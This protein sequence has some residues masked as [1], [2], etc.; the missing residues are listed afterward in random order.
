[1]TKSSLFFKPLQWV[2][3]GATVALATLSQPACAQDLQ[4]LKTLVD[5]VSPG[6]W[7]QANT[8][9]FISAFPVGSSAVPSSGLSDSGAVVRAWSSFTWDSRR[10]NLLLFGGGHYNYI[11]NEMYVWNGSTGVWTRGSLPSAVFQPDYMVVDNSAPQSAHTYDNN[12]FLPIND[13]FMTFGGATHPY[14]GIFRA[15]IDGAITRT[16]PWMWNPNLA[17]AG[18]VGGSGGSGFDPSVAGGMMWSD[19]RLF[20]SGGVL[21]SHINGTTAY[22]TENGK[23]VVYVTSDGGQSGL[24]SLFRYA[25]GNVANGEMDQTEWIGR[26]T[27]VVAHEGAGTIDTARNL[28]VRT[29]GHPEYPNDLLIWKLTGASS[30]SVALEIGVDLVKEDGSP[31]SLALGAGLDYDE[32][33]D[34]YVAWDGTDGGTVYVFRAEVDESGNLRKQ[35]H[36][37]TVKSVTLAQPTGK[38]VTGVFGKWKYVKQLGAYVALDEYNSQIGDAGVW[39]YKPPVLPGGQPNNQ[40]PTVSLA[41]PANGASLVVGSQVTLAAQAVDVDGS[42]AKVEFF[43]G[44]TSLGAATVAPYAINWTA[45]PGLHRLTVV[46][47]DNRGAQGF[48]SSVTIAVSYDGAPL[49]SCAAEGG[50]CSF[51]AGAIVDVYFGANGSYSVKRAVSGSLLC[52]STVFGGDPAPSQPKIC[53]YAVVPV[54]NQAPIVQLTWPTSS[55][56]FATNATITLTAAASDPDGSVSKVEF[57]DGTTVLG[58]VAA[59]PYELEWTPAP[60]PHNLI[61]RATD[62]EGKQTTSTAF[63][64]WIGVTT[65]CVSE[66]SNCVLPAGATADVYYGNAQFAVKRNLTGAVPCT[67]AY[68]GGDPA[69]GKVKAC[70]YVI[71]IQSSNAAPTVALTSPTASGNYSAGSAV[72]LSA[73]AADSDGSIAKVEFFDGTTS[74]GVSTVA[75]YSLSWTATLGAHNITAQATDN[76][77]GQ[78][79]SAAVAISITAGS[80]VVLCAVEN[81]TCALPPGLVA[82]VSYGAGGMFAIKRN[83]TGSFPCSSQYFGADPAVGKLKSCYYTPLNQGNNVAPTVALTSPTA[84]GSYS[85]GSAI[86]LSATAADSDGTVAKVEFFDGTTSLGVATS[87]PYSVSWTATLGSHNFTAQVTDNLGAQTTSAPVAISISTGGNVILCAVEGATCALPSGMVADVSYGANGL[88]LV[89]RNLTGSVPCNSYYFGG[90]PAFG[91]L[92]SC[93]YTPVN[94][95]NNTAPMVALTS[96]TASGSYSA[97]SAVVLSATASDND[98]S[99]TSVEFFDGTTSLG[100]A[101]VAPYGVSWNATMGSHV[102]TARATDNLGA[103]TISA[104]VAISITTGSS[105]ILCAAEG[106]TCT[107]PSG[108]LADVAYGA[109]GQFVV[110]R[111]VTGSF[112]CTS[113]YFGLDPAVGKLKA[114]YYT[115]IIQGNNVAPTV[116]LTSPTA[117]GTYSAGAAVTLSATASDSDGSIA[118]VE[119]F[120]GATSLGVTTAAPYSLS[121]TATLGSHD[122]TARATD[123]LGA[124]TTSAP[125]AISITTGSNVVLCAAENGTCALPAG[126]VADVSYGAAGLFAVKRNLSGNVACTNQFFGADPAPNKLKSCY[127]AIPN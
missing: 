114:C 84:S 64:V 35:W 3:C 116:A 120:D 23:D 30:T 43:D 109:N 38:F 105:G 39:L 117:S 95:G 24:P 29:I 62:N 45:T 106:S 42:I 118:K 9:S 121:W 102:F 56:V 65:F 100:V 104:S 37:T 80:N 83:L 98:G 113:Q 72:T 28:F 77:G 103:Q 93:Y 125:V 87:V 17:D 94:Q 21:A 40:L 69:P 41:S 46:A 60:G 81:A 74:L 34:Q 79:T 85:A 1:M 119:F 55:G 99:V 15:P 73:T 59:A 82:D 7:V 78:A 66:G 57:L 96:P 20:Q 122:F 16:G 75:P 88:F 13:R 101:T 89:K 53:L 112:P 110:K 108:M 33:L 54:S 91:K 36:A 48:S 61:A 4:R 47:T 127:Y 115:Q 71:T 2:A 5:S 52:S 123:N 50:T 68:F 18:K 19:R 76:L 25:V 90:D 44:L 26:T 12:N 8:S 67:S 70:Y 11:G 63:T 6:S 49:L 14:G 86:N 22:R 10:G 107:L 92:K 111:N 97:G 27:S 126:T 124:L 58:S 31:L 51:P 32:I